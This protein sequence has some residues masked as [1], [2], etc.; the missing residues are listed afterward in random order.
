LKDSRTIALAYILAVVL[1]MTRAANIGSD[2]CTA[3]S[4]LL[5]LKR[6]LLHVPKLWFIVY[7]DGIIRNL[8][9]TSLVY[10]R[11]LSRP[12]RGVITP[13][14]SCDTPQPSEV[15]RG[16]LGGCLRGVY[17]IVMEWVINV[18]KY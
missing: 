14:F 5:M 13:Q 12:P 10:V 9:N 11:D 18:V 15:Q 3:V 7:I 8:Y 2:Y 17:V 4:E 1:L 16:L 6:R